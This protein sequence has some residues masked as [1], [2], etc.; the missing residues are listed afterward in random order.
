MSSPLDLS[1]A[2]TLHLAVKLV[3]AH[4]ELADR[5]LPGPD[6]S[7]VPSRVMKKRLARRREPFLSG[8][9]ACSSH[10]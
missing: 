5:G 9:E 3:N 10:S 2:G 6:A 4:G 1:R 7:R 8:T